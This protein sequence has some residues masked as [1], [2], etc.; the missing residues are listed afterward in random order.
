IAHTW[1][2]G[3]L[4]FCPGALSPANQLSVRV[5]V[6]AYGIPEDPATGSGNGCLAGYL[7]KHRYWGQDSIEARVEQG[8]QVGRPSLLHLK[9]HDD[10]AGIRVQ[11]GGN[12]ITVMS[13]ELK[14]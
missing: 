2:Q 11:V 8:H 6:E 1:P 10:P 9:A 13:G 14:M 3:I 4:A 7:V 5:F 12:A